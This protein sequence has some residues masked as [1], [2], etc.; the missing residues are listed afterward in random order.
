M[1][2]TEALEKLRSW[3]W[4]DRKI[5]RALG[6]SPNTIGRIRSNPDRSAYDTTQRLIRLA[7]A[8]DF[9]KAEEKT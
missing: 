3:G 9:L 5:A 1:N 8:L 2:P 7:Y 6:V 4:S